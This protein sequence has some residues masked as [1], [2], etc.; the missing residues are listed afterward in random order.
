MYMYVDTVSFG[1]MLHISMHAFICMYGCLCEFSY[2]VLPSA[3]VTH[4][5]AC[6]YVCMYVCAYEYMFSRP[7]CTYIQILIAI[8]VYM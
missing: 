2:Q 8:Y 1:T 3:F 4:I 5:Y 6:M 7:R